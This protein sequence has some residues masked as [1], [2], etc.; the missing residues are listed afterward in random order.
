MTV[1]DILMITYNSPDY[2]RLSLPRLLESCDDYSRVWLWHNGTDEETLETTRSFAH[3]SRVHRFHHS[4]ENKRLQEPTAWLWT[5]ADGTYV[6]KVDDDC[7]LPLDW[8][9][10]LREAHEAN[11]DFGAIGSS[12]LR[13]ED[14]DAPRLQ[15]KVF[16]YGGGV[17]LFR[18]HWIQGS[19]YLLKRSL[20]DKFGLITGDQSWTGYCLELAQGGAINGFLYP[21]LFEDH[22]DDPRSVHTLLHSDADLH[23]RMPLSLGLGKVRSLADWERL[24]IQSNEGLLEASLDLK[25]YRG[26]RLKLHHI[27]SRIAQLRQP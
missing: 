6:S 16:E 2:V 1:V 11:G 3:D 27:R 26:W 14:I 25:D 12:R 4:V 20:I 7:L 5:E 13:P 9:I 15:R 8:I 18:N 22:M 10:R 19:G 23:W 24:L 17:Q 21:L